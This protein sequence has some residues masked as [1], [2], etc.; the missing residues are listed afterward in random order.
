MIMVDQVGIMAADIDITLATGTTNTGIYDS[1]MTAKGP[2]PKS[3]MGWLNTLHDTVPVK[4]NHTIH[5]EITAEIILAGEAYI[6]IP[7]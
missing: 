5:S 1:D 6:S 4:K 2:R 3:S 7:P